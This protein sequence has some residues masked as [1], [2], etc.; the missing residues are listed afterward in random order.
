MVMV[1]TSSS[2]PFISLT[3][4]KYFWLW[5]RQEPQVCISWINVRLSVY[6][7]LCAFRRPKGTIQR[8]LKTS[9]C[10]TDGQ[11]LAWRAPVRANKNEKKWW[12]TLVLLSPSFFAFWTDIIFPSS[13][14]QTAVTS[15]PSGVVSS[16]GSPSWLFISVG[17]LEL[18]LI[19]RTSYT[20]NCSCIVLRVVDVLIVQ[21]PPSSVISQARKKFFEQ[22][23]LWQ[24]K[25]FY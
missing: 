11:T 3:D 23:F 16:K 8:M 18:L 5:L 9:L 17:D 4:W 19:W 12:L 24:S 7:R 14:V 2:A 20:L 10:R 13:S 1:Y 6:F 15:L 21:T 22:Y 25:R